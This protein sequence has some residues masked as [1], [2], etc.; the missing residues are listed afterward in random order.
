MENMVSK[1]Q[2]F[3]DCKTLHSFLGLIKVNDNDTGEERFI[4]NR[5][6]TN[7]S[8]ASVLIIDECSMVSKQLLSF[9]VEAVES[10][11]VNTVLFIGDSYQLPPVMES[12][13]LVFDIYNQYELTQVV[14][15]AQDSDIIKLATEFRDAITNQKF[16]PII[17]NFIDIKS[18]DIELFD[19]SNLFLQD[20]TKNNKWYN[21]NKII[22]SYS[23]K[24]VDDFN[25]DIRRY[26]WNTQGVIN[27]D[28]ILKDDIVRFK[29][30]LYTTSNNFINSPVLYQNGE[31][32]LINSAILIY[33]KNLDISYWRCSVINRIDF[34]VIDLESKNRLDE[35]LNTYKQDAL[36]QDPNNRAEYWR[37]YY[38]LKD[39]F[40]DIKYNFAS[41]IHKLQG[42]TYDVVYIDLRSL[43]NYWM[44]S[45]DMRYR[46]AYVAITR[47]RKKIKILC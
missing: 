10:N 18:K 5:T 29:S 46:L 19:D 8:R 22:A 9:I 12:K 4:A 21:E 45:D 42:S 15:Q 40:A 35:I 27:P 11:R 43:A 36:H 16:I 41:T 31:E 28:Y 38:H 24:N 44:V 3:V 37:K 20:F 6:I 17:D 39:S 13:S 7:K 25:D 26:F 32:V 47:A 33:D 2:I 14:R 34:L 23:N 30:T 1:Q